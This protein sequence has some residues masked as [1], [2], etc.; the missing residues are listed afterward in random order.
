MNT[1]FDKFDKSERD[2][3]KFVLNIVFYFIFIKILLYTI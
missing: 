1:K 3:I 2:T